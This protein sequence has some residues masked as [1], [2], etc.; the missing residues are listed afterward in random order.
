MTI[1]GGESGISSP[2]SVARLVN[3]QSL[4]ATPAFLDVLLE[5]GKTIL[6][7]VIALLFMVAVL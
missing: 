1:P 4:V 2:S 7:V 6:I 5:H 3:A